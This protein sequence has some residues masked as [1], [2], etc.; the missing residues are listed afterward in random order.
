MA[1]RHRPPGLRTARARSRPAIGADDPPPLADRAR[2]ARGRH[3]PRRAVPDPD[4]HRPFSV[5]RSD[6]V[7]S[8][9]GE[10]IYKVGDRALYPF[11]NVDVEVEIVETRRIGL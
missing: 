5:V 9:T 6:T 8:M 10:H 2:R 1:Q 4:D 7:V 11:S 3:R